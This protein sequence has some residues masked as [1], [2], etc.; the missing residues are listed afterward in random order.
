MENYREYIIQDGDTIISI[1]EKNNI[2]VIDLIDINN[3]QDV[4][5]LNPGEVIKI[6]IKETGFEYYTVKKGDNLY[7]ISKK[8]NIGL[9]I[10]TQIN[11]LEDN[12]YIYPEQKILVPK[13]GITPYITKIGD[14]LI[15][16]SE[17][18]G[19]K[20]EDLLV[21]NENIYLLPEQLIAFRINSKTF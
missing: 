11:G 2:R 6:P 1:A 15:N 3:L 21:L 18:F 5:Y 9:D 4:Y 14:T 7:Q 16:L 17:K 19:I 13:P 10:L 20:E 12:E 8:F